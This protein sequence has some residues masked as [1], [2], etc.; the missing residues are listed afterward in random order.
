MQTHYLSERIKKARLE[1]GLSVAE[2]ASKLNLSIWDIHKYECG[3]IPRGRKLIDLI[4]ALEVDPL[5]ILQPPTPLLT[6]EERAKKEL[7]NLIDLLNSLD[8]SRDKKLILL[9]SSTCED[10]MRFLAA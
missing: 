6:E 7:K 4:Q 9:L 1:A 8:P 3:D 5:E 10:L 2:L